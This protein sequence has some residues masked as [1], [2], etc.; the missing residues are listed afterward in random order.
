MYNNHIELHDL[1]YYRIDA[2]YVLLLDILQFYLFMYDDCCA[3]S[4]GV[5]LC[6]NIWYRTSEKPPVYFSLR[7]KNCSFLMAWVHCQYIL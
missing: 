7:F 6:R 3:I 5:W 4:A 1:R 2:D